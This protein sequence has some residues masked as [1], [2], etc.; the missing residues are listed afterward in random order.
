MD[1]FKYFKGTQFHRRHMASL[2]RLIK[3]PGLR[4]GI[5]AWFGERAG[6]Y[7]G[8]AARLEAGAAESAKRGSQLLPGKPRDNKYE[9]AELDKQVA[10]DY[11]KRAKK[12]RRW[13]TAI[14]PKPK[15]K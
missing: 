3:K 2:R 10:D 1:K 13:Q 14:A 7:E 4:A 9:R 6:E 8:A 11:A 5:A 15:K 12:L